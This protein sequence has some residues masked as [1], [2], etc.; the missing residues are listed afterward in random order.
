[1]SSTFEGSNR[2]PFMLPDRFLELQAQ[3]TAIKVTRLR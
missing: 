2:V 3:R 1:M